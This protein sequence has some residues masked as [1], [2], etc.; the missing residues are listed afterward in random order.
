MGPGAIGLLERG[1]VDGVSL[2]RIR[3]IAQALDLRLDWDP[4]WRGSELAR[5]RDH[6]HA[7]IA[8]ARSRLLQSD[9]WEVAAELSFNHF[10]DRGRI[11]LL[12]YHLATGALLVI[13][14]KTVIAD[15]QALLGNLD[16]KV[17]LAPRLATQR[18]WRPRLVTPMLVVLD[19]RTNRRRIHEHSRLFASLA[20]RGWAARRWLRDP[21]GDPGGLLLFQVLPNRYRH[22]A[23][24]AGRQRV[25]A[26]RAAAISPSALPASGEPR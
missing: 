6:D 8:E 26:R 13:E 2:R 17:R 7:A 22:D 21:G 1:H 5:L 24:R 10:G 4:G 23:R 9:R 12:A 19:T 16:V 15:V 18:G 25:R 20:L 3:R 11:D 14:I